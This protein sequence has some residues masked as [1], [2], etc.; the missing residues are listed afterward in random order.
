MS[1][2]YLRAREFFGST[3]G[4]YRVQAADTGVVPLVPAILRHSIFIQKIHIEVTTLTASETWTF[5]DGAGVPIVPAVSA[6]AI[7]HFDFDFGPDG[8]PCTEGTAFNLLVAGATGAIG[9]VTWE[10]LKKHTSP[11]LP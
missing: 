11:L 7:A 3:S 5:Q 8:V 4:S 10:S 6:G 2:A 9:F 1:D